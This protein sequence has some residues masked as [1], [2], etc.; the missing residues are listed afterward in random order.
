M[1]IKRVR[2][3]R[4]IESNAGIKKAYQKTIDRIC[5]DFRSFVANEIL[6]FLESKHALT[7]DSLKPMTAE[8]RRKN[9]ELKKKLLSEVAKRNPDLLKSDLDKFISTNIALWSALVAEA[10]V[11]KV[12][13][14][15]SQIAFTTSEAQRRAFINAKVTKG[16]VNKAFTV[17]TVKKRYIT[18]KALDVLPDII[19]ENV[20][21]I[22]KINVEDVDRISQV[23][24]K[25]LQE[26]RNYN[27]LLDEL[28]ATQGFT[29][30]RAYTVAQ[31]QTNKINQ[32]I[33]RQ[34]ALAIGCTKAVWIHVAG[35][36]TSRVSHI[37]MNG[38]TFEIEKGCY[39]DFEKRFVK[40][41]ELIHCRCIMQVIFDEDQIND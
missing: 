32:F 12:G 39:D 15:I 26:G 18:Q 27:E 25:G 1:A 9:R 33:Q 41:G 5:S 20:N 36:Y 22:T 40:P 38:K 7:A 14:I 19:R 29:D 17:P 16:L 37:H 11:K 4:A 23:I 24:F 31:D 3:S 13:K 10:S 35:K 8:E 28:K 6:N 21:L 2:V 34:N 30:R